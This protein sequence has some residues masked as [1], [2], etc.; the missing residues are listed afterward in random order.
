M[1]VLPWLFPFIP[2]L[3]LVIPVNSRVFLSPNPSKS[4]I[5]PGYSSLT[6]LFWLFLL[7]PVIYCFSLFSLF[8]RGLCPVSHLFLPDIPGYSRFIPEIY[9]R[10]PGKT[11][12]VG[13]ER[14]RTVIN[15]NKPGNVEDV[16]NVKN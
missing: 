9:V 3:F 11:P 10:N 5:K 12:R 6:W 13:G 15:R 1:P 16:G 14:V 2:G 4:P 7:F 8:H